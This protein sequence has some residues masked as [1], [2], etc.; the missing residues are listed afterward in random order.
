MTCT[1]AFVAA[2]SR[3]VARGVQAPFYGAC[4]PPVLVWCVTT[5]CLSSPSPDVPSFL[6]GML[7][8]SELLGLLE[9]DGLA[10]MP[11]ITPNRAQQLRFAHVTPAVMAALTS[12]L[13]PAALARQIGA[14]DFE[15][16]HR[17]HNADA[18]DCAFGRLLNAGVRA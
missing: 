16:C 1:H 14:P 8:T 5:G 9:P 3:A 7:L 13:D 12:L 15:G 11:L 2:G 18:L 17:A 10:M 4:A 6:L